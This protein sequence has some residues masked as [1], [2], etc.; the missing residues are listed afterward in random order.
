MSDHAPRLW[1]I[2]TGGV[3]PPSTAPCWRWMEDNIVLDHRSAMPGKYDT[4]LTPFVRYIFE[5]IQ[6]PRVK[7]VTCMISAQSFKSQLMLNFFAW[8]LINDPGQ[9]MWI[10]AN[11]EMCEDF[12]ET[13]LKSLLR[14][15]QATAE[16]MPLARSEDRKDLVQ[17]PS[18]DLLVRGSNSRQKLQSTP[19]RRTFC[20]ERADW[21]PGA[22]EDVRKRAGTFHN[23]MEVSAGTGG[24]AGDAFTQDFLEGS[25]T[26]CHFRCL[27]CGHSQPWR[28]GREPTTFFPHAR[29]KGGLRWDSNETTRPGGVWNFE[30]VKKTVRWECEECGHGHAPA[31]KMR[32]I[33]TIHAV[34]HNPKAAPENKSFQSNVFS[35]PWSDADWRGKVVEWLLAMDARDHHGDLEPLKAF[36]TKT[37]GEPW[38]ES[39]EQPD[40]ADTFD[41]LREPYET[42]TKWPAEVARFMGVDFQAGKAGSGEHF[43]WGIRSI[44]AN[45][46]TRLVAYGRAV[47]FEDLEAI[48]KS[49]GVPV[50]N[51]VVDHGHKGATVVRFCAATGWKPFKGEE[52]KWFTVR[53]KGGTQRR[54][55]VATALN[56]QLGLKKKG[57]SKM[58]TLYRWSNPSFKDLLNNRLTGLTPGFSIPENVGKDWLAHMSA[59][60]RVEVRAR[61]GTL[62]NEWKKI[63]DDDHLRDVE[64]MILAA[65]SIAAHF[66]MCPMPA[67]SVMRAA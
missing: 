13:R 57:P 5:A 24:M 65:M 36:V 43:W 22:I 1:S 21:K 48:R 2:L 58:V 25:Q 28:F 27:A 63:R 66:G 32:M 64:L 7:K 50:T 51:C 8:S 59:E 45:G 23:R 14:N 47:T 11:A 6:S 53:V 37:L 15:C 9:S 20:D 42:N 34:E 10:M 33:E 18:M 67:G 26:H 62:T 60:Q 29:A 4:A 38:R 40:V 12:I 44:A 16:K 31:D 35:M 17:F 49:Y 61:D 55:W 46:H 52:D 30:E 56:P 41:H 3:K 19:I 39:M 54:Y